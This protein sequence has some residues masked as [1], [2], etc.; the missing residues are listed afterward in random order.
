MIDYYLKFSSEDE[1]NMA[2]E[3]YEGSVDTIGEIPGVDGW[4]V[5]VRGI[6]DKSLSFYSIE[7]A[8]LYRTWA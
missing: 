6:E 2:L 4:H 8:S 1:A 3:G 7:V 5:N